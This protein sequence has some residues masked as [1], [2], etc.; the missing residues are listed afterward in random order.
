MHPTVDIRLEALVKVPDATR[1]GPPF[2]IDTA[3]NIINTNTLM[4]FHQCGEDNVILPVNI[5][6]AVLHWWSTWREHRN[7]GSPGDI[8][9]AIVSL[10]R[11]KS[12]LAPLFE[13]QGGMGSHLGS[14]PHALSGGA[15]S[16]SR[17]RS[18]GQAGERAGAT[19]SRRF[20]LAAR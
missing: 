20:P 17:R 10:P 3:S 14:R 13:N 7:L 16:L 6:A 1:D 5:E 15:D 4:W 11:P 9:L 12:R 2:S 18:P 19:N 8:Y